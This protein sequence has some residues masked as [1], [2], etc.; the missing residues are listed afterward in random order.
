MY[1]G[2]SA[3]TADRTTRGAPS[4]FDEEFTQAG[5]DDLKRCVFPWATHRGLKR[6][7][8]QGPGAQGTEGHR[9]CAGIVRLLVLEGFDKL[10]R[11]AE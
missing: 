8:T 4:L 6:G 3:H 11:A 2:T 7:L 1:L 10:F 9:N 5:I